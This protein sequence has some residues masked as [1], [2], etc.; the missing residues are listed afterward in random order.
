MNFTRT[1]LQDN[2]AKSNYV[3]SVGIFVSAWDDAGQLE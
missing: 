3:S 2:M 1:Q